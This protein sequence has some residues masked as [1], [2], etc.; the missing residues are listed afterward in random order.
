MDLTIEEDD[1]RVGEATGEES[2]ERGRGAAVRA[3]LMGGAG[4]I[5]G[6]GVGKGVGGRGVGRGTI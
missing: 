3:A 4:S 5:G 2:G 1:G 6:V